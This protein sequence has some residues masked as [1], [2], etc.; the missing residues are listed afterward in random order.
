MLRVVL[1][2]DMFYSLYL[3]LYVLYY[4]KNII[5]MYFRSIMLYGCKTWTI[6]REEMRRI[7]AFEMWCYKRMEK[8]NWT[9]RITNGKVLE[10]I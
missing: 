6:V 4:F 9:D 3:I 5:K 2:S 7:E 10:N 1:C 8:I